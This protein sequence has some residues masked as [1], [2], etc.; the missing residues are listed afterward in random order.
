[1]KPWLKYYR[2]IEDLDYEEWCHYSLGGWKPMPYQSDFHQTLCYDKM[3]I[4]GIRSGKTSAALASFLNQAV[5]TIGH[6][7]G[8]VSVSDAQ[9]E[10]AFDRCLH[11]LMEGNAIM[12]AVKYINHQPFPCIH[13]LS[14]SEIHFRS[15]MQERWLG[16]TYDAF[17]LDDAAYMTD[18][19]IPN[20]FKA[21]LI[22]TRMGV[23]SIT[24]EPCEVGPR[25]RNTWLYNLWCGQGLRIRV[26]THENWHLDPSEIA[27]L[28]GSMTLDRDTH[29]LLRANWVERRGRERRRSNNPV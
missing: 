12:N 11:M 21:H 15:C 4:G 1:M 3:I 18:R 2:E 29:R 6:R 7:F 10:M 20:F 16:R 9:A 27:E 17:N 24:S 13:F 23:F 5:Y 26:P 19:D 8:F 14:D 28:E 22:G 25:A